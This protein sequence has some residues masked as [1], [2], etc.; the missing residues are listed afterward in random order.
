M[1]LAA[2]AMV[3]DNRA[4]AGDWHN[5]YAG[6]EPSVETMKLMT[7]AVIA[8]L[9]SSGCGAS[10]PYYGYRIRTSGAHGDGGHKIRFSDVHVVFHSAGSS[11]PGRKHVDI[12][13]HVVNDGD[14]QITLTQGAARLRRARIPGPHLTGGCTGM[15]P[16][17]SRD[18]S[19]TP[20]CSVGSRV[21]L[22]LEWVE[23][24]GSLI[25]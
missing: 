14:S 4:A 9:A 25:R 7:L 12:T 16:L 13:A 23:A 21:R 2:L 19:L 3:A 1:H 20:G 18:Q 24:H 22:R 10:T 17:D 11:D 5:R 8:A 6:T 15:M